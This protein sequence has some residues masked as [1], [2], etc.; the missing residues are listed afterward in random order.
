MKSQVGLGRLHPDVSLD[1]AQDT[2]T[3]Q[4]G[5]TPHDTTGSATAKSSKL[6]S[7]VVHVEKDSLDEL[8]QKPSRS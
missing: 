1:H 8:M 5:E 3:E 6:V 2:L 4:T 7:V